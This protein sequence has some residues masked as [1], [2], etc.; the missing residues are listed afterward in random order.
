MSSEPVSQRLHNHIKTRRAIE[1]AAIEL[2][3]TEGNNASVDE[4]SKKANVSRRTFFNYYCSKEDAMLGMSKD[5]K[6]LNVNQDNIVFKTNEDVVEFVV[7]IMLDIIEDHVNGADLKKC[8]AALIKAN[9]QLLEKQIENISAMFKTFSDTMYNAINVRKPLTR[10]QTDV[11]LA[12]CGGT[13]KIVV[14]EWVKQGK[15]TP[16]SG[17]NK[18]VTTLIK[19]TIREIYE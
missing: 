2:A 5:N 13:I 9:P 10:Q 11:L 18:Q 17:I 1:Q 16:Y 8:R 6:F 15:K 3:G 4:I 12:I 7:R 19:Q 14:K